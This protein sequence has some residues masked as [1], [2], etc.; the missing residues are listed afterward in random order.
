[1]KGGSFIAVALVMFCVSALTLAEQFK[2]LDVTNKWTRHTF[3][4]DFTSVDDWSEPVDYMNGR[5]YVRT[6]VTDKPTD[7]EVWCQ[8]CLWKGS[9]ETCT[10]HNKAYIRFKEEGVYYGSYVGPADHK[11]WVQCDGTLW[12]DGT[13][14]TKILYQWWAKNSSGQLKVLRTNTGSESFGASAAEHIPI[15][16]KSQVY[17]VSANSEFIPPADWKGCPAEWGCEGTSVKKPHAKATAN[18]S[19]PSRMV[20]ACTVAEALRTSLAADNALVYSVKG[21]LFDRTALTQGAL[22]KRMIV[23]VKTNQITDK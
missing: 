13:G 2:L 22:D 20:K 15:Y 3:Y 8:I 10:W 18:S 23:I 19:A 5:L 17:V 9:H 21:Q 1:M 11:M 16:Y 14:L 7:I 6:E 4:T 12:F